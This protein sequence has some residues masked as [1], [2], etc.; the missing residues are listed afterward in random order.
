MLSIFFFVSVVVIITSCAAPVLPTPDDIGAETVVES[1]RTTRSLYNIIWGCLVTLF[2]CSWS[3]YRPDLPHSDGGED[4]FAGY[5]EDSA[6]SWHRPILFCIMIIAPEY[7]LFVACG[8]YMEANALVMRTIR[9]TW[10]Q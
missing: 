8:Q 5:I 1:D 6:S 7:V 9:G 4:S 2:A 10:P 3:A